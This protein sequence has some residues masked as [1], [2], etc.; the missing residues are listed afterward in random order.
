M[1]TPQDHETSLEPIFRLKADQLEISLSKK[2][3]I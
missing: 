1:Y 3:N 2:D